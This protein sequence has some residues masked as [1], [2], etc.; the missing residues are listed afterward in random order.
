MFTKIILNYGQNLFDQLKEITNFENITRGREGAVLVDNS[1]NLIPLARST[2]KY[3][4][5][6]QKFKPIHYDIMQNIKDKTTLNKINFN[7]ALIE[8]YDNRYCTMGFHSDQALDLADDSY[9][10][11][12]SCYQNIQNINP[13]KLIIQ[14]KITSE[15]GEIIMEQNSVILFQLSTNKQHLHKIV[16][17][18]VGK[19]NNQWLGITFRLSKTFIEHV[20]NI[21]YFYQTDNVLKLADKEESKIYYKLRSEE[22]KSLDFTYPEITYTISESD[23]LP[24]NN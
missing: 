12:Y 11:I 3:T 6:A 8:I 13:R 1:N 15:L 5:P 2:T 17:E 16:L 14:N 7:N 9:I 24:I 23:L 21:P 20:N 22:N 10:A 4:N 18:D 19:E